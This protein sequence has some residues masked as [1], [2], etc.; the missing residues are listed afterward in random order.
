MTEKSSGMKGIRAHDLYD[1][2]GLA[3]VKGLNPVQAR[4][5]FQSLVFNLTSA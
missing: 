2:H 1:T 3:E 5:F 4:I